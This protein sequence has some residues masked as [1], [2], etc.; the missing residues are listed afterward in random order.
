[1]KTP[2]V[3]RVREWKHPRDGCTARTSLMW[4][5]ERYAVN[6][7]LPPGMDIAPDRWTFVHE[8]SGRNK[9][10]RIDADLERRGFICVRDA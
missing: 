8:D 7:T 6:R 1:M 2:I 5:G 9:M 4:W 3:I 10:A